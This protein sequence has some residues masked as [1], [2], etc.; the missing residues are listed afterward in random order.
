MTILCPICGLEDEQ[1]LLIPINKENPEYFS[2]LK[3]DD[4]TKKWYEC[5]KCGGT[6]CRDKMKKIWQY[7][8]ATYTNFVKKGIIADKLEES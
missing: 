1:A 2:S 8:P 5:I 4:G 3:T 6:F 7:S